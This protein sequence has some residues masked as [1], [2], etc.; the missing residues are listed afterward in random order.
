MKRAPNAST[1]ANKEKL[2][3]A[4]FTVC[5]LDP[6]LDSGE[7]TKLVERSKK[8]SEA[9]IRKLKPGRVGKVD[10]DA[11]GHVVY[12]WQRTH[13]YLDDQGRPLWLPLRSAGPSLESLFR[14]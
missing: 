3:A 14:E 7:L 5:G 11:L 2:L 10:L 12:R 4:V 1:H 6:T 9:R 13:K 8:L